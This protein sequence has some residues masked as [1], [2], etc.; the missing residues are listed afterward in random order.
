MITPESFQTYSI[1]KHPRGDA[2]RRILAASIQAVDPASLVKQ[3]VTREGDSLWVGET[4]H[5]LENGRVILIGLGKA[6][7]K[8]AE[9][10]FIRQLGSGVSGLSQLNHH[11]SIGCRC[12]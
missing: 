9:E 11:P 6:A 7:R 8:R 10:N 12:D 1:N 3:C 5:A 2:I 4:E